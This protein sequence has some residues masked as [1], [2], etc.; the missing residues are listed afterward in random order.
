MEKISNTNET[1]EMKE[2]LKKI[3]EYRSLGYLFHGSKKELEVVEPRQ[4][5]DENPNVIAGNLNA[6]YAT[7]DI[8]IPIV[9]ALFDKKDRAQK[10]ASSFYSAYKDTM[11]V[12]GVNITFTPGYIYVLPKESFRTVENEQEKEIVSFEPVIPIDT[13]HITPEILDL[14]PGITYDMK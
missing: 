4:A 11:S 3:E 14:I 8:R 13:I 12:G 1:G 5:H 7:N 6:I 2:V 9:I 10:S